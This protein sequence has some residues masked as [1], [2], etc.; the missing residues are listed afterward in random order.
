[1]SNEG[2]QNARNVTITFHGHELK[3]VIHF[4]NINTIYIVFFLFAYPLRCKALV[5]CNVNIAVFFFSLIVGGYSRCGTASA[6]TSPTARGCRSASTSTGTTCGRTSTCR[7]VS[8]RGRCTLRT[9]FRLK[10]RFVE[11]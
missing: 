11:L 4:K 1:M 10:T 3:K 2:R 6:W 5:V 9:P 8:E 7:C